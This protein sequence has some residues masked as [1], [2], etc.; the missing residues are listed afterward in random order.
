MSAGRSRTSAEY[1]ARLKGDV[2][3]CDDGGAA[4]VVN[5]PTDPVDALVLL[6]Q[7]AYGGEWSR[8]NPVLVEAAQQVSVQVWHSCTKRWREDHMVDDEW[9]DSWWSPEGDG[10]RQVL[11]AFYPDDLYDLGERART[12]GASDARARRNQEISGV[13]I[14]LV[15]DEPS[16]PA[17]LTRPGTR[18]GKRV[19]VLRHKPAGGAVDPAAADN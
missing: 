17:P 2:F 10:A 19:A 3:R 4:L 5:E 7:Y 13:P 15:T 14:N 16:M 8:S 11:V 1:V 18:T 9:G 6:V 12:A